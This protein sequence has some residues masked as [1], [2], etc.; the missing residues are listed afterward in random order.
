MPKWQVDERF[1]LFEQES[2]GGSLADE[3]MLGQEETSA[4]LSMLGYPP[5]KCSKGRGGGTCPN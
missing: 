3:A 1:A 2:N 4:L 5:E